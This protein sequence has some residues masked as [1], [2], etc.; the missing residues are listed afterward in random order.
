[1]N[2]LRYIKICKNQREIFTGWFDF[3]LYAKRDKDDKLKEF[4]GR[5][6]KYID[7]FCTIN[8]SLLNSFNSEYNFSSPIMFSGT[9]SKGKIINKERSLPRFNISYNTVYEIWWEDNLLFCGSLKLSKSDSKSTI[10]TVDEENNT[11]IIEKKIDE[12]LLP[13]GIIK[14]NKL[15]QLFAAIIDTKGFFKDEHIKLLQDE[16][17]IND[18][19]IEE[20]MHYGTFAPT[21]TIIKRGKFSEHK[22]D[23][24][25]GY[26]NITYD[27]VEHN[28]EYILE[29][30]NIIFN[31]NNEKYIFN[32]NSSHEMSKIFHI[33]NESEIIDYYTF[34]GNLTSYMDG[35]L[36]SNSFINIKPKV[37]ATA[38][39]SKN[40]ISIT[41]I[42]KKES[43]II[44][45]EEEKNKNIK[46]NSKKSYLD[47]LIGLNQVK[48]VFNL[49]ENFSKYKNILKSKSDYLEPEKQSMHMVFKG[50][51]GT[52]KTT[53]AKRVASLLYSY[54]MLPRN[55]C[56]VAHRNDLVAEYIG[57][58]EAKVEKIIENAMGGVLFIDEAYML[59]NEA[60]NDYGRIALIQIMDAM[61]TYKGELVIIL[62][63]YKEKMKNLLELNEGLASRIKWFLDFEDY[64]EEELGKILINFI[65]KNYYNINKNTM[66]IAKK[67]LSFLQKELDKPKENKF[68]FGNGRG[69]L[70]FFEFME[71]S[72]ASRMIKKD[73]NNMTLTELKTFSP[74]DVRYAK[75][76]FM[77]KVLEVKD[78]AI[79]FQVC[80]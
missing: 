47:D 64:S 75:D 59:D 52:G 65:E 74:E 57:Q 31:F 62:A 77:K 6:A 29:K 19:P 2:Y 10:E 46:K 45:L 76:A 30:N 78:T 26:F 33:N 79:G 18:F 60:E 23:H 55:S 68:K 20:L 27:N 25:A 48:E 56:F 51:P 28:I 70:E 7:G 41:D 32:G 34:T 49:F 14:I 4:G 71:I 50:N 13:K 36:Q 37:S 69:V 9:I 21:E 54:G 17:E 15:K 24:E 44:N 43:T 73:Y 58:T 63:G 12:T 3:D 42:V 5:F 61:E 72:L 66:R 11:E 53:V 67:A 16:S 38:G 8:L 1:M 35:K 39:C 80:K 40:L 22:I